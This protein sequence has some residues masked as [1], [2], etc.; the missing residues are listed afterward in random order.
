MKIENAIM[1]FRNDLMEEYGH[2][3]A[4][5]R[6]TFG[7]EMFDNIVIDLFQKGPGCTSCYPHDV[8]DLKICGIKIRPERNDEIYT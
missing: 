1:K 2:R 8:A 6:I 4:P 7:P 5:I 3:A